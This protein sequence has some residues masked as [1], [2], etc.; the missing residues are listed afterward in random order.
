MRQQYQ[1]LEKQKNKI[2]PPPVLPSGAAMLVEAEALLKQVY[3]TLESLQHLCGELLTQ[4]RHA[5]KD[6]QKTQLPKDFQHSQKQLFSLLRQGRELGLCPHTMFKK[7]ASLPKA[8]LEIRPVLVPFS[9][10]YMTDLAQRV[11]QVQDHHQQSLLYFQ[12]VVLPDEMSYIGH[13]L[14]RCQ[15]IQT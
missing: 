12:D 4:G 5:E 11:H 7:Y 14:E 3:H 6:C 9:I 1:K 10:R 13:L 2:L 15:T 8:V